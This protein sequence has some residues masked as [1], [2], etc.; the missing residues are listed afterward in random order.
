M[1]RSLALYVCCTIFF[2]PVCRKSMNKYCDIT[3]PRFSE[4]ILGRLRRGNVRKA[5][6]N[7]RQHFGQI[8]KGGNLANKRYKKYNYLKNK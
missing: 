3:K 6:R 4:H 8:K 1:R 2:A 7:I 5:K